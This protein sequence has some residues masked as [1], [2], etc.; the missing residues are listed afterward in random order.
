MGLELARA[1]WDVVV[2]YRHSQAPAEELCEQIRSLDRRAWALAADLSDPEQCSSLIGRA[3]ELAGGL[4]ALICNA[5]IFPNSTVFDATAADI[6]QSVQVHA[7][8]PLLLAQALW[9]R[10]EARH[11]VHMLD[12]KITGPDIEHVAYHLSKRM[13][14]DLTRMLARAFAPRIAVNAIAPGPILPAVDGDPAR[15]A[16]LASSVPL[17]TT[18]QPGDI[19]Q[20]VLYLLGSEYVTGQTL[21]VDGGRHLEGNLYG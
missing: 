2:H 12:S 20:A 8:A 1:G 17:K 6:Q 9:Q 10:E 16:G 19:T 15:F 4:E 14:W 3:A 21:F 13:L 5:S 18:G 11:I 7:V